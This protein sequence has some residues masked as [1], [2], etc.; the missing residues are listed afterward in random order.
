MLWEKRI[1]TC[2]GIYQNITQ[3]ITVCGCCLGVYEACNTS[4]NYKP[5]CMIHLEK[6]FKKN[7]LCGMNVIGQAYINCQKNVITVLLSWIWIIFFK[8]WLVSVR[9]RLQNKT[10]DLFF[11]CTFQKQEKPRNNWKWMEELGI[12]ISCMLL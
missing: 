6:I 8:V 3:N 4:K 11:I 1:E 7:M 2:I 10:K 9:V 5:K 12:P